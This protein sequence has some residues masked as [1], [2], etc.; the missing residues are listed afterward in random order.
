LFEGYFGFSALFCDLRILAL[1]K[2]EVI[3]CVFDGVLFHFVKAR[4]L[5]QG[6]HAL[7]DFG[8]RIRN[9]TGHEGLFQLEHSRF[10]QLNPFL[11]IVAGHLFPPSTPGY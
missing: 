1:E 6:F 7:D 11:S 5:A 10:V 4:K 3:E 8:A 2:A 9:P